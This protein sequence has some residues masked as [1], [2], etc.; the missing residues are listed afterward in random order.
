MAKHEVERLLGAASALDVKQNDVAMLLKKKQQ[1][2]DN[3]HKAHV[4]THDQA[5]SSD[6]APAASDS[7]QT[8]TE[9]A[10]ADGIY[11]NDAAPAYGEFA[12][13]ESGGGL[14]TGAW[15]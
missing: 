10:A 7:A 4:D 3:S 14:S 2:D 6:A 9:L 15:V 12:A 5:A 1:D 8:P 13:S 11:A